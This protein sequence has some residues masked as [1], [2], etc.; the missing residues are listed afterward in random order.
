[1]LTAVYATK[2]ELES[3]DLKDCVELTE[4]YCNS[5][6]LTALDVKTATKLK[7]FDCSSNNLSQDAFKKLFESL[8]QREVGDNAMCSIYTEETG[9]TEGNY[10]NF[11]PDELNVA[12]GRNWKIH[13]TDADGAQI[14]L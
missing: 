10:T 2:N 8:P 11:T 13:K 9:V 4:L 3:L 12:K 5:N 7:V 6:K 14:E 1:M